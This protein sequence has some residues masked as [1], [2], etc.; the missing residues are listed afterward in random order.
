MVSLLL[1][2]LH[3]QPLLLKKGWRSHLVPLLLFQF[4]HGPLQSLLQQVHQPHGVARP[5]LKLLPEQE[6]QEAK[7]SV[8][9]YWQGSAQA[10]ALSA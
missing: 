5:G 2:S 4:V 9:D 8:R 10:T 3:Q 6:R 7:R 1:H